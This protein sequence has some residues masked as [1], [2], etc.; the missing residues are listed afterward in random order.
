M[1]PRVGPRG[2]RHPRAQRQ[3]A[4]RQLG[5]VRRKRALH[6]QRGGRVV[7]CHGFSERTQQGHHA[8]AD[9]FRGMTAMLI[10]PRLSARSIVQRPPGTED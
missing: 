2:Y 6:G 1:M 5:V 4:R 7:G 9:E 10:G 3:L 8:V